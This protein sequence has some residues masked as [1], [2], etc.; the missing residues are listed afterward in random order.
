MSDETKRRISE[1]HKGK[2]ISP[3]HRTKLKENAP[4]GEDHH[5]YGKP[6][7]NAGVPMSDEKRAQ[8][9]S[10]RALNGCRR[11][12]QARNYVDPDCKVCVE[13]VASGEA[14]RFFTPDEIAAAKK[15]WADARDPEAVARHIEKMKKA[16]SNRPPVTDEQRAKLSAASKGV[17]KGPISDE[18]RAKLSAAKKGRPQTPEQKRGIMLGM[19]KKWHA[20]RGITN[21]GCKFCEVAD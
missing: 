5:A 19:H 18:H 14:E 17:R 6:A 7:W 11:W 21:P 16:Q 12:H 4:R 20:D 3:E 2:A 10:T 9:D 15:A 1:A 13:R 8:F